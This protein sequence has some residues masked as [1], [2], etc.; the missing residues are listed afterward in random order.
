MHLGNKIAIFGCDANNAS[1]RVG[2]L[3]LMIQGI[4]NKRYLSRYLMIR[5]LYE[6]PMVQA[7]K[8]NLSGSWTKRLCR[9]I[10]GKRVVQKEWE[11]VRTLSPLHQDTR[12]VH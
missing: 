7:R 8:L 5:G 6:E 1:L 3:I 9:R 10:F 2:P 12:W 4:C 11:G